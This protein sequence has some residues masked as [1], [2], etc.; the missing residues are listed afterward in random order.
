MTI[1]GCETISCCWRE[2][3]SDA[4]RFALFLFFA[5]WRVF[6]VYGVLYAIG[7]AAFLANL[8]FKQGANGKLVV[9]HASLAY[10][11]AH[12]RLYGLIRKLGLYSAGQV[13][14]DSSFKEGYTIQ[15]GNKDGVKIPKSGSICAFYARMFNMLLFVWPFLLI[16]FVITCSVGSLLGLI[17]LGVYVKPNL[18]NDGFLGVETTWACGDKIVPG[19]FVVPAA[20][21]AL[22]IWKHVKIFHFL[23]RAGWVALCIAPLLVVAG[24]VL[25]IVLKARSDHA[26]E[27][28]TVNALFEFT[29]ARKE[30]FCKIIEF[31]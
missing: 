4:G 29:A 23:A 9:D 22:I 17:L 3:V 13:V 2:I 27:G 11:I 10:K 26:V 21:I 14:P 7:A 15:G 1:G 6:A 16:Y 19:I 18:S 24:V 20:L 25:Y 28:T 12:P 31:K 30:R 8:R 5:L